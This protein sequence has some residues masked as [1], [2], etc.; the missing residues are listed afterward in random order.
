LPANPVLELTA[1]A[2]RDHATVVDHRDLV[3]ELICLLEVLGGEQ[4]RRAAADELAY[5][6]PD[7]IAAARI[8][9]GRGLVQEQHT[10]AGKQA[11]CEVETSPHPAGVRARRTVGRVSQVKALEQLV[12]PPARIRGREVEQRSEHLQVL[13]ARQH[14]VDG[15]E[16]TGQPQELAHSRGVPDDIVAKDL[17]PTG[18]RSEQRGQYP[19]EGCLPSAVRSEQPEDRGLL[20]IQVDPG[21]GRGRAKAFDHTLDMNRRISHRSRSKDDR[22]DRP[23]SSSS[24]TAPRPALGSP[25]RQ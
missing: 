1:R 11:R 17:G 19:D 25:G 13:P 3:G 8:Q 18:V 15:R 6:R 24:P 12:R 20:D 16:L 5:D 21:K 7:L 10:R 14:L 23:I 22:H 9:A 4:Q 2:L